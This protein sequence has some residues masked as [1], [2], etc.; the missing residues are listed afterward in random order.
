LKKNIIYCYLIFL[1]VQGL[2]LYSSKLDPPKG[3]LSVSLENT[4]Q[5][6]RLKVAFPG[7]KK[8]ISTY[9]VGA[10]LGPEKQFLIPRFDI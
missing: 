10:F 8:A 2:L 1:S 3:P 4:P 9:A 7:G 5:N 6:I